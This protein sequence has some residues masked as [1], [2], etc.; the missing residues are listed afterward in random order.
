MRDLVYT[1]K[2]YMALALLLLVVAAVV[3]LRVT[4]RG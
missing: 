1:G 2:D 3:V 4:G